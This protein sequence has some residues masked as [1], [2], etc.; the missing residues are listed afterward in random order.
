[1]IKVPTEIAT[2]W[3]RELDIHDATQS[4]RTQID[5]TAKSIDKWIKRIKR[6]GSF[7]VVRI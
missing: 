4:Q 3:G 5:N 2:R 6:R 7:R 1:L